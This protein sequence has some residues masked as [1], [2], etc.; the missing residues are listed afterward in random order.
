[1]WIISPWVTTQLLTAVIDSADIPKHT[2]SQYVYKDYERKEF[3]INVHSF[4]RLE[5]LN[6]QQLIA[7]SQPYC[8]NYSSMSDE[9]K[10]I[11]QIKG[12]V[13]NRRKK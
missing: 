5:I 6:K 10:I 7:F 3:K 9:E 12:T 11:M 2:I 4:S 8:C 13:S 1:M